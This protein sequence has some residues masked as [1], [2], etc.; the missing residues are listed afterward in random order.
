MAPFGDVTHLPCRCSTC[1]SRSSSRMEVVR[2]CWEA[3]TGCTTGACADE[4]VR[5]VAT[6][7]VVS[8]P[9]SELCILGYKGHMKY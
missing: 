7:V 2:T 3:G 1:S 4:D 9:P 8:D 5:S 6:L